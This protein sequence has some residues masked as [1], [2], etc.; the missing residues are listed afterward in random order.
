MHMICG[1][2]AALL[3]LP[4]FSVPAA[5]EALSLFDRSAPLGAA[6][7]VVLAEAAGVAAAS[8]T[9]SSGDVA[10]EERKL[11]S[12]GG[13]ESAGSPQHVGLETVVVT[14]RKR[15][16][17]SQEVPISITAMS[18]NDLTNSNVRNVTEIA[19]TVPN[20]YITSGNFRAPTYT[21][22][23][24]VQ[25]STSATVDPSVGIYVDGVYWARANGLNAAFLDVSR[26][27]V[28]KGP[29]GTLF[30]RNTTGGAVNI[31]TED[32]NYEG[33]SGFA[34]ASAGNHDEYNQTFG[35]NLPIAQD[36][37]AARFA[38]SHQ[39]N[40]GWIKNTVSGKTVDSS[41]QWMARGK[42]LLEPRDDLRIVLS[43]EYFDFHGDGPAEKLLMMTSDGLPA[44][45]ALIQSGFTDDGTRFADGD[46]DTVA[47]NLKPRSVA[48][49]GTY[50]A[51]A[52]LDTSWGNLKAIA[53]Y[54]STD[55]A[56]S[57][58]FDGTPYV[59]FDDADI[60]SRV[61]QWSG[62]LQ[63]NGTAFD[64]RLDW[65]A[66]VFYFTED[67]YDGQAIYILPNLLNFYSLRFIGSD[68]ENESYAGYLQGTYDITPALSLTAG[69]RY[70][71]DKRHK[72]AYADLV[73]EVPACTPGTEPVSAAECRSE[74]FS[75]K[76]SDPS[77]TVGLD[78]KFTDD[79]M[80]Y[81]KTSRGYRAGG[82]NLLQG[83]EQP[84]G[85]SFG[86][87][88]VT[89][90]EIGLK[91]ELFDRRLRT[92]LAVFYT[93]Y[94]DIQSTLLTIRGNQTT[95]VVANAAKGRIYGFELE[96]TAVLFDGFELSAALGLTD[97]KYKKFVDATGDRSDEEFQL[98]PKWTGSVAA[99]YTHDL[100]AGRLFT[101]ADYSYKDRIAYGKNLVPPYTE[102][103]SFGLVNARVGFSPGAGK[104][105]IA[106]YGRNLTDV[107]YKDAVLDSSFGSITGSYSTP[108]QYGVELSY[109]F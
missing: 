4:Y 46:K 5:A 103:K 3:M 85:S 88:T 39:K 70:S 44:V 90:Y 77:Y 13:S 76:D 94:K 21:M 75:R 18:G 55:A 98:V 23:G 83:A 41:E 15:A 79:I 20:M 12:A 45:E 10:G 30:G 2:G 22:R 97:A 69:V 9:T 96:S 104:L 86:P 105:D 64:N 68:I 78:Y 56:N 35:I 11:P 7:T 48:Q 28:L 59:L 63:A 47:N 73:T 32:P 93:D 58:D 74:P 82:F 49:S 38:V 95:V 17:N 92:N 27:E 65:T 31:V 109:R 8:D 36:V 51:T 62:E 81:V 57:I 43:A 54:R 40:G 67:G 91:S 101:R 84:G 106:A 34:S 25:N 108:R 60:R 99:Q 53:A 26:I 19:L 100:A 37:A 66:G 71:V 29:Q 6:T 14:A 1:S 89:D 61:S 72:Q 42:F 16:E 80:G 107:R 102:A 52:T 50:S 24:Q 33:V 87:E